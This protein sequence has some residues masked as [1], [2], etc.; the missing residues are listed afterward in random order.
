M[1]IQHR[2]LLVGQPHSPGTAS[3]VASASTSSPTRTPPEDPWTL[4][5][6]EINLRVVG[7]RTRSSRFS[8]SRRHA[9]SGSGHF[10]SLSGRSKY[11]M[12][13]DNLRASTYRGVLPEDLIDIVTDN[14]LHYSH[15]TESGVLFH[16]I[17]ALSEYG[18]LGLTVI[19]NDA[20]T[21][22][23][24]I[25]GPSTCCASSPRSATCRRAPSGRPA[26]RDNCSRARLWPA[27]D[28]GGTWNGET[29]YRSIA[30]LG[31]AS[32]A[33]GEAD[34]APAD[35]AVNPLLALEAARLRPGNDPPVDNIDLAKRSKTR[36]V[37]R[38][39][40]DDRRRHRSRVDRAV[41]ADVPR[42]VLAAL[43]S[44]G[45]DQPDDP[46]DAHPACLLGRRGEAGDRGACRRLLRRR[47]LPGHELREPVPRHVERRLL[48]QVADALPEA[49]SRRGRKSGSDDRHRD[50]LQ[51]PLSASR[52]A[53]GRSR[54]LSRAVPHRPQR[55]PCIGADR[56]CERS[57]PLC[58]LRAV[59][60][61]TRCAAT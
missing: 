40:R 20:P 52:R 56:R 51:R 42:L 50:F 24:C 17:G 38:G 34:A 41:L 18:K 53:P 36:A 19:G 12:A 35:A 8:S 27:P 15:R 2:S 29:S 46:E 10:V 54:L 33:A 26:D 16:L 48:L 14:G 60:A 6:L 45:A 47:S 61:G 22:T 32:G 57:R 5:A 3:S 59:D 9:G 58:R 49:L 21:W 39:A 55:G 44:G 4:T 28:I 7:P 31:V 25:N 11:Y 1:A 23:S 37:P 43:E 13:T 30:A